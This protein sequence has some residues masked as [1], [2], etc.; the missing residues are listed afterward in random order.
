[1]YKPDD[2]NFGLHIVQK[3]FGQVNLGC[4][5]PKGKQHF[6]FRSCPDTCTRSYLKMDSKIPGQRGR[7][8]KEVKENSNWIMPENR[9]ELPEVLRGL[10]SKM[11]EC[12]YYK[13]WCSVRCVSSSILQGVII[14]DIPLVS[15]S[16]FYNVYWLFLYRSHWIF[17][18]NHFPAIFSGH[19]IKKQ[20]N[21]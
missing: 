14:R 8:T 13:T 2:K 12:T 4:N 5:L 11:I 19:I 3:D 18:F 9:T 15:L 21:E 16:L 10:N 20:E 1:M 6:F 7:R 17:D